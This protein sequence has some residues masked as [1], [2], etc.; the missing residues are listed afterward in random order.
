MVGYRKLTAALIAMA[1][2]TTLLALHLIDGANWVTFNTFQLGFFFSANSLER[3]WGKG[4]EK[5][6]PASTPTP[7]TPSV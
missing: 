3:L 5:A 1:I 7:P 4:S 2:S 6:A